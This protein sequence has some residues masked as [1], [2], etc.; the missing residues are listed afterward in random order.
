MSDDRQS[1]RDGIGHKR[2]RDDAGDVDAIEEAI[3]LTT[4]HATS[5][6]NGGPLKVEDPKTW[7]QDWTAANI[8]TFLAGKLKAEA[9]IHYDI[10]ALLLSRC[11]FKSLKKNY[12][13]ELDPAKHLDATSDS[14]GG[15][16]KVEDPTTWPQ[17][18]KA[19]D[20]EKFLDGKLKAEANVNYNGLALFLSMGDFK[21]L[22]KLYLDELAPSFPTVAAVLAHMS[23]TMFTDGFKII[24]SSENWETIVDR[25]SSIKRDF[26]STHWAVVNILRPVPSPALCV[27]SGVTTKCILRR[28]YVQ[29]EDNLP[30]LMQR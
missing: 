11:D 19:A 17:D 12:L 28:L 5:D 21:S 23:E 8:K 13:H 29:C 26:S 4:L 15:S 16:L 9:K 10:L 6:S 30:N 27:V 20:I 3:T 22:K 24:T 25:S 7:P 14:K 1:V 2:E 18:W